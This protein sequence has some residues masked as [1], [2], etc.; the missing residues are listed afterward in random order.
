MATFTYGEQ[1]LYYE[2]HGEGLPCLAL[3]GGFGLDHTCFRPWLDELSGGRLQWIYVD[4]PGHGRSRGARLDTLS[5]EAM[6]GALSALARELAGDQAVGVLGHSGG[7]IVAQALALAHPAQVA[8]LVGVGIADHVDMAAAPARLT[9]L[10]RPPALVE[11]LATAAPVDDADF[12]R[13]MIEVAP[14]YFHDP[15][16]VDPQELLGR[17]RWNLAAH[18]RGFELLADWDNRDRVAKLAMPTLLLTGDE[19]HVCTPAELRAMAARM[20]RAHVEVLEHCGHLPFVEQPVAF[21][22]ALASWLDGLG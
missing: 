4:L 22:T 19:D 7:G 16:V 15:T 10:G 17:T 13:I 6:A 20:P 9:E 1:E 2:R 14:L 3:H 21:A 12:G 11:R 8:F 5:F 18:V